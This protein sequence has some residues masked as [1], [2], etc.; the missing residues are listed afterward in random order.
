MLITQWQQNITP[1]ETRVWGWQSDGLSLE[2]CEV[3]RRP[4]YSWGG[5]WQCQ[6]CRP[7]AGYLSLH[8]VVSHPVCFSVQFPPPP[9]F[10]SSR[11]SPASGA[12]CRPASS[13]RLFL[14]GVPVCDVWCISSDLSILKLVSAVKATCTKGTVL[15][16]S[17]L[18]SCVKCW[19]RL[20]EVIIKL[21]FRA[22]LYKI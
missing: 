10:P 20:P 13:P 19:L 2:A 12:V 18:V 6:C 3:C 11:Q 9:S 22:R 14:A 21:L 4:V 16:L 17:G 15:S 5:H 1:L 7:S 8:P